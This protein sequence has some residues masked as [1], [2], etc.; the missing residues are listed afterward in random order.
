MAD[1]ITLNSGAGGD[2]LA[3][4]DIAGVKYQRVKISVGADGAAADNSTA[5]P[6]AV[7]IS[8]GTDVA[9]VTAGGL[10]Q[11]DA[12][13]ATVPVSGTVTAELSA[14]DNAVLDNIDA[15]L[16]TVIGHVDG[17]ETLL[18][19]IDADTGAIKTAV[20]LIDNAISGTEMQVDIVAALPAGTNAIGK[21]AANSG[22]DIGDV[23]VLSI[24]PGTGATNLGK[25]EDAAHASGDTGVMALTVRTNTASSRSG[26][27]GDYQP[28]IT[29][30]NGRLHTIEPSQASILTAVQLIDN[31]SV[32]HDATVVAGVT[33]I[34]L[35]ARSAAPTAVAT[36]D[37]TRALATLLGKQVVY[38]YAIPA[39]TWQYAGPTGGIT[40]TADDAIQ[41]AGGAGVRHYLT[42]LTVVNSH[43]TVGTEVV[44]KDGSTV[45]HRGYAAAAGGG[46]ALTFPTPLRGTA[47]TA[48]N[49]ACITTGSATVISASGFSAAE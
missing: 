46:Y 47:A 10:L 36:G 42:S 22:V 38:P 37:A 7:K 25:A 30:T 34:G 21:L 44:I 33:Q 13:G 28:L 16:T 32:N 26:T 20:E 4:D 45:I 8:D 15:D 23:D 5:A 43:A 3:A 17:I 48:L 11:V 27:D 1:D 29:D 41:A 24:V 39:E 2:T 12:S 40:D 18:G 6:L 31:A 35:D 9:T 19:T 14:V 49:V